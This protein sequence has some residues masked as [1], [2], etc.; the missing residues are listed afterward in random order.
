VLLQ[1]LLYATPFIS[2]SDKDVEA[3][4]PLVNQGYPPQ[5][6]QV[7]VVGAQVTVIDLI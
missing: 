7:L 4:A 2:H 3:G 5:Q 6:P 1:P